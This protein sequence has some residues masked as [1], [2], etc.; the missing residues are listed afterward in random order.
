M[1]AGVK[2]VAKVA[3]TVAV[4]VVDKVAVT[5]AGT[6]VVRAADQVAVQ[7]LEK[8]GGVAAAARVVA[9]AEEMAGAACSHPFGR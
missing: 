2:A 4:T 5:A 7:D 1:G 6:V 8:E 3:V 9:S